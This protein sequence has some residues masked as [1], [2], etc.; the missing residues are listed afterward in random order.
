MRNEKII[1]IKNDGYEKFLTVNKIYIIFELYQSYFFLIDDTCCLR[2]Y[3]K[4]KFRLL[5]EIRNE[6]IIK[7]LK[8][9]SKMLK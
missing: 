9:E 7:L 4:N 3:S 6:K 2:K 5:S 8:D 1:C